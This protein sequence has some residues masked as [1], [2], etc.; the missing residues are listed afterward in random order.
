MSGFLGVEPGQLTAM[1]ATWRRE[2]G[3][4]EALSW[5]VMHE[6]TGE[7]SDV[8]A[9]LRGVPDAARQAMTSIATRYSA[10]SDLL[11][12]F[13]ADIEAADGATAAEITKLEPR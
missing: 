5:A 6:A 7:G 1:A 11:D 12:K 4:V 9:A 10:L 8:L 13:S 3:A 2:A